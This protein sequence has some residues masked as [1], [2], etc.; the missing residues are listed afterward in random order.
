MAGR[1]MD[2]RERVLTALDGG[3]PDRVPRALG[4]SRVAIEQLAPCGEYRDDLV[5][6]Q[7]IEFPTSPEEAELYRLARPFPPDTRLGTFTQ[8]A[9]YARWRYHPETPLRRNPLALARSIEDLSSFPFPDRITRSDASQLARQ[10]QN[11]HA[12]GLA[13][14]GNMPHLGGELFETA[15]RLRGLE[16]FLTD[17]VERPEWAHFLLDRLTDLALCNAQ[18]LA[19]AGIDILALDDDVGMPGTMIISPK[20]WREFLKPRLTDI[21][22]ASRSV[23]PDLRILFHS[24]GYFEPIIPD[25]MDIGVN[26]INPLQP[27]HMDAA[28]IRHQC[29]LRLAMWGTVGHQTTFSFGSP[30]SVRREVKRRIEQL[31]RAGLILCPAYDIGE[32]DIPWENISAFVD[33]VERYG[34]K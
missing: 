17:L 10:V 9:T 26:A 11:L 13:A 34:W 27:D 28:R 20:H 2:G 31:G 22:Q 19:R 24:D 18:A 14:G 23:R 21:I 3:E 8:T 1:R 30:Q 16:N 33:A 25:L 7:F 6:V 5:D 32:P 4:F 12:C 29:G 15:W